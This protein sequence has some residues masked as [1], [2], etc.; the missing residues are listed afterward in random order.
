MSNNTNLSNI[1]NLLK[2]EGMLRTDNDIILR[3]V[4][5]TT[6]STLLKKDSIGFITYENNNIHYHGLGCLESELQNVYNEIFETKKSKRISFD[7]NK[8]GDVVFGSQTYC[9]GSTEFLLIYVD[10]NLKTILLNGIDDIK[11]EKPFMLT[12]DNVKILIPEQPKI[13]IYGINTNDTIHFQNLAEEMA[14]NVILF[15]FRDRNIE[16]LKNTYN[17]DIVKAFPEEVHKH[18]NIDENTFFVIMTHN[19]DIDLQLLQLLLPTPIKYIG[20]VSSKTRA[21]KIIDSLQK[22]NPILTTKTNISKIYSPCGIDLNAGSYLE[23][24]LSILAE[25][26]S[27]YNGGTGKCLNKN[28]EHWIMNEEWRKNNKY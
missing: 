2:I 3:I 14:F 18:T 25:I 22:T 20:L 19:F 27:I 16:Y 21:T 8:K 11:Q 9:Q 15:D 17:I 7:L 4:T 24:L 28:Y 26:V 1:R 13:Y 10:N 12:I 6:G 5:K 23:I